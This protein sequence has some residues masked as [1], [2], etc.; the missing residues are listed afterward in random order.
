MRQELQHTTSDPA[1]DLCLSVNIQLDPD[2]DLSQ[3]EIF[4]FQAPN[5]FINSKIVTDLYGKPHESPCART[6]VALA[7]TLGV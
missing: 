5:S 4:R 6:E 3:V 7:M 2:F 1:T